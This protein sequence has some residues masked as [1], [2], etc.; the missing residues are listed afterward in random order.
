MP[1]VHHGRSLDKASKCLLIKFSYHTTDAR[2]LSVAYWGGGGGGS[3]GG[4]ACVRARACVVWFV[5][6]VC[7]LVRACELFVCV[8]ACACA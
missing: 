6:G 1:A 2:F 5:C 8:R 3:I 7:A 4:S